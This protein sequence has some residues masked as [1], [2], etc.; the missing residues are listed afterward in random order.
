MLGLITSY[1]LKNFTLLNVATTL[2]LL[3]FARILWAYFKIWI[4][5]QSLKKKGAVT[6]IDFPIGIYVRQEVDAY[7][8]DSFLWVKN[9]IKNNPKIRVIASHMGSSPL[10][11]L[12]DPNLVKDF[13]TNHLQYVKSDFFGIFRMIAGEGLV[14]SEQKVWKK[15]RKIV[16]ET[17]RYDFICSQISQVE[18]T[19]RRLIHHQIEKDNGKHIDILKLFQRITGELVFKIFFGE[20][21]EDLSIDGEDPT[22]YL[23]DIMDRVFSTTISLENLILGSGFVKLGILKRNRELITR[24]KKFNKFCMDI[25]QKRKEKL[26]QERSLG[27]KGQNKDFLFLLLSLQKDDDSTTE[28]N[29]DQ[30]LTDQEILHEFVTFFVA[31]MDTTGHML[32]MAAYYYHQNTQI[33]ANVLKEARELVKSEVTSDS[34]NK[35]EVLHAFLKE[36]LRLAG[37]APVL[38]DRK[39]TKDHQ[40]G[41]IFV[42]KGTLVNCSF[43]ANNLNPELYHNPQEFNYNRWI[44]EHEDFAEKVTKNPFIFTPFS[45]G[46]RNCI[47]QHLAMIEGKIIFSLLISEYEFKIPEDYSLK[48]RSRFLYEP[49]EPL[50]IDI[51]KRE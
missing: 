46:S 30:S 12:N 36:T 15:H 2:V 5:H 51:Q 11:F 42:P 17:F 10:I 27:V 19:A 14:F 13:L 25:I 29:N 4:Y 18:E 33:Q 49:L 38:F 8:G 37:P 35:C 23:A 7:K 41:D 34:L 31:G 43:I 24:C 50:Y 48:M 3:L 9:A 32:T 44:R 1:I 39:A 21:F 20:D 16:S 22:I 6:L 28:D 47:G 40:I 26:I 45:A